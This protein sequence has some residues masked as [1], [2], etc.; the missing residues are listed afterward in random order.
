MA[1]VP[2][3]LEFDSIND[4]MNFIKSNYVFFFLIKCLFDL[5]YNIYS[6]FLC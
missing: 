5:K 2:I 3:E 1:E 6:L 4:K